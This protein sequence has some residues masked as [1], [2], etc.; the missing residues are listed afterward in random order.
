MGKAA[1]RATVSQTYQ[2]IAIEDLSGGLDLRRSPTLVA[3]NRSRTLR[4]F[5]LQSPG[6]LNVYPGWASWFT[7]SLGSLRPQGAQRVY[8]S[9]IVLSLVGYNGSVYKPSDAGVPGS[10]VLAGLSSTNEI[11]FPYDRDLVAVFDGL[12]IPKKT[13]DGT[14]WYQL[15]IDAPAAAPTGVASAPGSLLV[16]NAYEFSYSY[17]RGS[18]PI[19]EGNEG[20]TLSISTGVADHTITL[21]IPR[22]TDAQV[23]TICVYARDVTAGESVRRRTGTVA[24]PA[25]GSATF[26]VSSKNWTAADTLEAPT[27]HTVPVAMTFGVVWKNRWWGVDASVGNRLRFTQIFEPQSWPA[28]FYLDIP[29]ERG[30]SIAAIVAQGDTLVICGQSTIFLIIG[31]TSLDFEVRPS[32][33]SQAGALGPRAIDVLESGV[34]HGASDGVYIFDGATD[35][36]LT[37]EIDVAWRSYI[38]TAAAADL[39]KT[40]LIYDASRKELRVGVTVLYPFGTPGEWLL[41]LHRTRTVTSQGG[42]QTPAWTSTDRTIGGYINWDGNEPTTGN[43]GRLFSWGLTIGK[44][45]EEAVGT[46]ADG[47]NM[48]ADYEGPALATG[49][50]MARFIDLKGEYRPSPSGSF[51]LEPY[52]DGVSMGSIAVDVTGGQA[53]YGSAEYGDAQYAGA[54]RRMFT[55]ELPMEAEGRTVWTRATY[56]GKDNFGW[57]TYAFGMIPEAEAR[58]I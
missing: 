45:Y 56:V 52:V 55:T 34:V 1:K 27:D 33:G 9:S 18:A 20:P 21:T 29:F 8:L 24:N 40:P 48:T 49:F 57:F 13:I 37:D 46:T 58:G 19:H 14:T 15:G 36:L 28:L 5:S 3:S 42:A 6:E 22:S 17:K 4:N 10:A 35:R 44:V 39:A 25:V 41:D 47:D 54:G 23:D 16:S 32:L 26:V 43:R 30:D 11:Y 50:H 12:N 7:S 31:Q 53:E 2:R 38:S 51:V